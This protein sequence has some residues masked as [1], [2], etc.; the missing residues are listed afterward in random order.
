MALRLKEKSFYGDDG[1]ETDIQHF[2]T[3]YPKHSSLRTLQEGDRVL[4][5]LNRK[6]GHLRLLSS[7]PMSW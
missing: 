5:Q 4:F 6:R 7:I 1:G 2:S 3:G